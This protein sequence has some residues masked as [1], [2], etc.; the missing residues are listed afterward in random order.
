LKEKAMRHLLAFPLAAAAL[1]GCA[2]SDY[3][4]S[5]LDGRRYH[6]ANLD[7]YPVMVIE[8]DGRSEVSAPVRVL[9]G[10]RDVAVQPAPV[11]GFRQAPVRHIALDVAPCTRYYLVAV[12]PNSI[13]QDYSVKVDH[14]EPVAGCTP[15]KG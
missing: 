9:P 1:C 14:E 7:T 8:V 4:Y 10:K 11:A 5:Q 12:R 13:S 6:R 3:A 2:T 15:P